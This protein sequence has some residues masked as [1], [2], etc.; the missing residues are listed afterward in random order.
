MGST[1]MGLS[2]LMSLISVL[3]AS[4]LRPLIRMA[5]DPQMPCAQER[6]KVSEPSCSHL[7]LCRPSRTRSFGSIST[8]K[9]CQVAPAE[10]S[11]L[12]RRIRKVT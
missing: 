3:Q 4:R 11:G 12:N 7:I 5:S 9:S 1:V 2:G 6:R 10:T 8:G